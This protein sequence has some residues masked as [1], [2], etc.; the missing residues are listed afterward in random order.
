MIRHYDLNK[1]AQNMHLLWNHS[2]IAGTPENFTVYIW[3][4]VRK[5]AAAAYSE[6]SSGYRSC[7]SNRA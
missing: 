1:T 7:F 4:K 5:N 3:K 6:P 2:L